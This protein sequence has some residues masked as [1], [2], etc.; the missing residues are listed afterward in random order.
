VLLIV[1]ELLPTANSDDDVGEHEDHFQYDADCYIWHDAEALLDESFYQRVS[2][3]HSLAILVVL[4][5][6]HF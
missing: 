3:R 2:L 4:Q 6:L 1:R 5:V